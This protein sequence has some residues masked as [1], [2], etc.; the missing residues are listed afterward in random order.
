MNSNQNTNYTR[1]IV[2]VAI[3]I[4]AGGALA[5]SLI[6]KAPSANTAALA[7]TS[8]DATIPTSAVSAST[9]TPVT[10]T[11]TTTTTSTQEYKDGTYSATGSYLSPGGDEKIGV[12]LTLKD[13]LITNASVTPEPVSPEGK[14]YQTIFQSNFQPLVVGKN[15]SDVKLTKVSGSSL[16]SQGFNEALAT[17]ETQAKA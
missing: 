11:V 17:I 8:A 3:I 5:Y 13:D 14:R 12:T 1:A 10:T 2:I 4:L 6:G 15:I 16:T 7:T 9:S